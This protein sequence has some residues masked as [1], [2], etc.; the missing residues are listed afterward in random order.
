MHSGITD[1]K[2]R[3]TRREHG[4]S[5]RIC[6][7]HA[8]LIA[9]V[10]GKLI[11]RNFSLYHCPACHFSFIGDPAVNY[12]EIYSED[13]YR[14]RGADPLVDYSFELEHPQSTIRLYEWRGILLLLRNLKSLSPA[15]R[16]LDYGCG[17]GALVR[18]ARNQGLRHTLGFDEG[19]I[20]SQARAKQIPILNRDQ[21][22]QHQGTFD[23]VTAIEVLEHVP[24]P[25]VTL[26]EIRGLL[27]PEGLFFCTTGNARP[28]RN[29]LTQWPYVIP[30]IHMSFYE[31]GSLAMALTRAG[32]KPEYKLWAPGWSDII[33]FKILKNLKQRTTNPWEKALPWNLLSRLANH[34]FGITHH[35]FGR[36]A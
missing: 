13:Y 14:G 8:P 12:D 5:C 15:T 6:E 29:H 33:R 30:E 11:Q 36:T 16:W 34:R 18:Y 26:R 3:I 28:Y 1:E 10:Q 7:T 25:L 20:V 24:N 2:N 31:P 4:L 22:A 19:A 21:L 17:N 9:R 35:P 27:K 32:F 23:L